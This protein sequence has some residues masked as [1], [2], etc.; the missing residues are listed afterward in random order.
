MKYLKNYK[1]FEMAVIKPLDI[2]GLIDRLIQESPRTIEEANVIS[3]EYNVDIVTYD[4]FMESIDDEMREGAPPKTAFMFGPPPG[5]MPPPGMRPPRGMP[6]SSG[7]HFA[8][9]NKFTNKMNLVVDYNPFIMFLTR[10]APPQLKKVIKSILGHESI[11]Y[12]Q[13]AKMGADT[14]KYVVDSPSKN[15]GEGYL[16]HHTEIMAHAFSIVDELKNVENKSK[17]DIIYGLKH[18]KIRHHLYNS[19]R[20]KF[21]KYGSGQF[22]PKVMNKLHKYIF[23]YVEE[24]Y[25]ED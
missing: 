5:A 4:Q 1:I 24:L 25:G 20:G 21:S 14:D 15:G 18:D 22:D 8:V 19:Y 12:Q 10:M 13:F 11:H 6:P 7:M 3:N 9:M 2:G 16:K 23:Q 17:E